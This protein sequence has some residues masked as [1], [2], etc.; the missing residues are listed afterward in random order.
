MFFLPSTDTFSGSVDKHHSIEQMPYQCDWTRAKL[1]AMVYMPVSKSWE[2][3]L[4]VVWIIAMKTLSRHIL[5]VDDQL[6]HRDV[7]K[8][9][10]LKAGFRVTTAT[11]AR[12]AMVLARKERFDLV[13]TDYDMPFAT[14]GEFVTAL[15]KIQGYSATPVF[16]VTAKAD[17]LD[18]DLLE[19]D[20]SLLVV[21]KP[22]SVMS[23]VDKVSECLAK[24]CSAQ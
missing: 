22:C 20:L 24:F 6:G 2:S 23:L 14:G 11:D 17:E 19:Q 16:L 12:E 15:R 10:L 7:M 21:P 3:V 8:F 13:I 1:W 18:G 4:A 9:Y 5:V